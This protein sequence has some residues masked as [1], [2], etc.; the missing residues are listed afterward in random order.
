M[1]N[2]IERAAAH[3]VHP[4]V[5]AA[6]AAHYGPGE[7]ATIYR[8]LERVHR[9]RAARFLVRDAVRQGGTKEKA[10]PDAALTL[11][12]SESWVD[13]VVYPRSRG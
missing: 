2:D 3:R 10:I 7:A 5:A 11:G 8:V 12:V 6:L 4:D 9:E 1:A 13:H